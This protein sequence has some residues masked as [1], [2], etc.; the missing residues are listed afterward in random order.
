MKSETSTKFIFIS[1]GVVSSLGKGVASASLALLLKWHGLRVT[2]QKF[3]PY[4]NVDAGTMNPFQHGEVFVTDDGAETD[5]DLGHYERFLDIDMRKENNTT[6]GQ[7]YNEVIQR[8]RRGDYL[9]ATVQVIP[10]ITDA[11]KE[12]ISQLAN[13]NQYDVVITEVGG[14]VGDIEGLPFLEAIRQFTLE[15]GRKNSLNIHVTLVPFIKTAG[16]LKTK[17]TQHSVKELQEIGVNP[18]I[19][20]CRTEHHLDYDLKKKIALFCNVEPI[21]VI[22]G[23]DVDSSYDVPVALF[24]ERLAERVLDKLELRTKQSPNK[25]LSEWKKFLHN[26]KYPK[27]RVTIAVVG[28]YTASPDAYK[29]IIEAFIHS[30]AANETRVLLKWIRAEDVE[31]QGAEK[32][33]NDVSGLLVPGGFGERGIEGKIQA[34]QFVR[35]HH[36]PFLG[37]CL[38]LQTAVIEFA[39]NVC[40]WKNAHSS[41]FRKTKFNVI[42]LLETQQS[43][44]QKG[45][46]MR[47]GANE[48]TLKKNSLAYSLY[49][50]LRISER[51]RHRYEVNNIFRKQLERAGLIF[52]GVYEKN[53]LVEIIEIPSHPFFIAGQFHCELKSRAMKPHPL[54]QGFVRAAVIF[55]K[56]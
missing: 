51:H 10:H 27:H 11:I 45:G 9:G 52:S 26:I 32:F 17:P 55:Q 16:E 24:E 33:L 42:D 19:I 6:T 38:G 36:I 43:V 7:I 39:R 15:R 50:S 20:I 48:A 41:E 4:I 13:S 49:Q 40:S 56:L 34:I 25:Q 54:F 23:H 8:E 31:E 1:G 2:I 47:L 37:I 28:K 5:L 22:E 3:D 44:K 12:R 53:N 29:S 35:E 46:T 21:D 30:G 18:D 14:T